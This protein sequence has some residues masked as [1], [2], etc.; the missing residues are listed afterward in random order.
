M[1]KKK[2]QTKTTNRAICKLMD[3]EG[4]STVLLSLKPCTVVTVLLLMLTF[5][6][7]HVQ[8]VSAQ[9]RENGMDR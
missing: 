1:M 9:A 6:N 8:R 5:Y 7:A 2:K 4:I 3:A